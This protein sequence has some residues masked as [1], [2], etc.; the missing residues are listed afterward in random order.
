MRVVLLILALLLIAAA[1]VASA[2]DSTPNVRLQR[3]IVTGRVTSDSMRDKPWAGVAVQLG[4]ERRV[5]AEDGGFQ[6]A[7]MPGKYSLKVCCSLRFQ[8]IDQEIVLNG[9]DDVDLN[10]GLTP[11]T[12]IEGKVTIERGTEP[13]RGFAISVSLENSNIVDRALTDI[14]G[15]FLFHLSAGKWTLS[16]DNLPKGYTVASLMLGGEKLRGQTLELRPDPQQ[17]TTTAL[18]LQIT[19]R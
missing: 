16:I 10:L 3:S 12:P 18:P 13:P 2:W 5:L 15:E 11:L 9:R 1:M 4:P 7:M 19:L 14:D 17:A 8:A 6:F